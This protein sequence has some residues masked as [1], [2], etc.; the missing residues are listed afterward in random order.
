MQYVNV[1]V[2]FQNRVWDSV[3]QAGRHSRSC[4]LHLFCNSVLFAKDL[5]FLGSLKVKK[6]QL[7]L[8]DIKLNN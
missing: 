1:S 2:L 5:Q 7:L 8:C 6:G 3:F 4:S